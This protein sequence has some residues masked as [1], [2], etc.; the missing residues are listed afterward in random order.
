[1]LKEMLE[2]QETKLDR[3]IEQEAKDKKD[4]RNDI[5]QDIR[6]EIYIALKELSTENEKKYASK[7][8]ERIVYWAVW[9]ILTSV[10]WALVYL[11]VWVANR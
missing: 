1:M 2:R 7:N 3:H 11:V 8:V 6:E 10:F 9:M 5:K 4:L